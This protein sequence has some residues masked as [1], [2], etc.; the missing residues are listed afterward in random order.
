[1]VEITIMILD[2]IAILADVVTI[3]MFI[4]SRMEKRTHRNEK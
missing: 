2:V 3:Y 4:E 1:M